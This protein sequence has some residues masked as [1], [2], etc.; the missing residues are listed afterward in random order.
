MLKAAV[1][2]ADPTSKLRSIQW[3]LLATR[4]C[5]AFSLLAICFLALDVGGVL[6][7]HARG[8]LWGESVSQA[9]FILILGVLLYGNLVYQFARL[10]YLTRLRTHLGQDHPSP[11]GRAVQ[12]RLAVLVPSYREEIPVVRMTLLSAAL[13]DHGDHRVV[14]LID[15][16]PEPSSREASKALDAVR[17]L[18][19]EITELLAEPTRRFEAE[20]SAYSQRMRSGPVDLRA[21]TERLCKLLEEAALWVLGLELD[22][23]IEVHVRACFEREVLKH[24]ASELSECARRLQEQPAARDALDKGYPSLAARFRVGI[25][26]FERKRYVNLAHTPNKAM[27]LNAYLS[28]LG[29]GFVE[30]LREDG[31]HLEPAP[32]PNATLSIADADYVLTLDADSLLRSDYARRL[33]GFMQDPA[34][35]RIAVVQTPYSAFPGATRPTERIAGATTDIQYIIH[36]GFTQYDATYWVGANAVIRVP[37]LRELH[38][39]SEERGFPISKF[40]SDHTVIEDT[41][42]SVDLLE[43]GWQLYNYPE[44][45][46]FSATPP[47]F[48][49]LAIQRARWANGGLLILPKLLRHLRSRIFGAEAWMRS[50]YLFSIAGVNLALMALL[51]VPFDQAQRT[52]WLPFAAAPYFGLYAWDLRSCGYRMS[53][54]I[55]VYALNLLMIPVNLE[56]V[57][58]SLWQAISGRRASFRRT[59]KVNR[60]TPT[61]TRH[62]VFH[63]VLL[64]A[65]AATLAFDAARGLW[66]H[67]SFVAVNGGLLAYAVHRYAG[68]RESWGSAKVADS[69]GDECGD[70]AAELDAA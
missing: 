12:S 39:S 58:Q 37:A 41:E 59:P 60:Q 8:G 57:L 33:I 64:L 10:G 66:I 4:L 6:W 3:N 7:L 35:S 18:P 32:S 50:H 43:R 31:L 26:S 45:M 23:E 44:R 47:D 34:H 56:G 38:T 27:N 55:R 14:L 11:P 13:L 61:E 17:Q 16:S 19:L 62:L 1:S 5:I 46:A 42:S 68:V 70:A 36:Q 63:G 69:H 48:G 30:R 29:G 22:G 20:H 52:W 2:Q 54:V 67:G 21:E 25:S 53:D 24:A 51:L 40:I 65:L 28:L 9:S 15:D 49:S